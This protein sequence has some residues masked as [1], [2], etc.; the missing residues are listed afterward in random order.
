M[1]PGIPVLLPRNTSVQALPFSR[2]V[3]LP[4]RFIRSVGIPRNS[5]S[6]TFS[7]G[8]LL[9][10]SSSYHEARMYGLLILLFPLPFLA[11]VLS[12]S[13]CLILSFLPCRNASTCPPTIFCY[14]LI[15]TKFPVASLPFYGFLLYSV[16]SFPA[17]FESFILLAK[18]GICYCFILYLYFSWISVVKKLLFFFAFSFIGSMMFPYLFEYVSYIKTILIIV[19]ACLWNTSGDVKF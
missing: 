9:T 17:D 7:Q 4:P 18:I 3:S 8:Q 2:T 13:L 6:L 15:F 12:P 10:L 19:D 1:H 5:M 16:F 14:S 11:I